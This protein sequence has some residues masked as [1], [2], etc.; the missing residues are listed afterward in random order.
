MSATPVNIRSAPGI[1]RDG[2]QFDGS[3]YIDALWCRFQR[4]LPRKMG[5]FRAVTSTLPERVYGMQVY[6]ENAT[7]YAHLGGANSLT[8]ILMDQFGNLTGSNARLPAGFTSDPNNLWQFDILFDDTGGGAN[9]LIAHAAPNLAAVD[10]STLRP[11]YFGDL[12]AAGALIATGMDQQSGG[13]VVLAPFLLGFGNA[14]RIQV[15]AEADPGGVPL[16]VANVCGTKIVRGFPLRGGGSGPAGIFWSLDSII[17]ATF[18]ATL[19]PIPFAF[20]TIS[21]QQSIM[22]SRSVIEYDGIFYWW[23]VDRPMMFNGV[24]QELPNDLNVNWFLDNL[25]FSQ[26]QK[27]FAVKVPR[28]GEIWW[29]F[30]FGNATECTHAIVYNVRGKFWYDTQLP[31]AAQAGMGR[32]DGYFAQVYSKPFM[33]DQQ[34]T[35]TPGYTLWQHETGTDSINGADIQPIRSY[36]QTAELSM[37]EMEKSVDQSLRVGLLEPDFVQS[38]DLTL[39]VQ[40]RINARAPTISSGPFTIPAIPTTG[41]TSPEDENNP[42]KEVR[43]LMSFKFESNVAG[44]DYQLGQ[45]M[46]HIEPA[47]GRQRS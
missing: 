40:G 11:I 9:K 18:D 2:T 3:N 27:V 1:K 46:A 30:P 32:T 33:C 47:D 6:S 35:A 19:S 29:C 16:G 22:S 12:T 20:D 37:L 34:L 41:A 45:T 26:R 14:G 23:A 17:R 10:S 5:G 38:G 36:F 42:L 7:Q 8:Q 44:G 21:S 39:T 43:R 31:I 13:I 4:G 25:N 15:S 24:P 28:F